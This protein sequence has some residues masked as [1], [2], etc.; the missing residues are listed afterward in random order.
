LTEALGRL[1]SL[2]LRKGATLGGVANQLE[3]VGGNGNFN[4]P[5][6]HAIGQALTI[7]NRDEGEDDGNTNVDGED[8][9][10]DSSGAGVAL[11]HTTS[12]VDVCPD[13]HMASLV[14]Q[15]GCSKCML[16]GYSRC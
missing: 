2:A 6:P 16:C 7:L 1:A 5:V 4:K 11:T 15:E 14:N 9:I 13:C 3:G 10:P 8:S 12:S